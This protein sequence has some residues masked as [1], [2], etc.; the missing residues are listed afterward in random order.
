MGFCFWTPY[1]IGTCDWINF[2]FYRGFSFF[3]HFNDE[4]MFIGV[5]MEWDGSSWFYSG[6]SWVNDGI[7]IGMSIFLNTVNS[8]CTNISKLMLSEHILSE[9]VRFDMGKCV[10]PIHHSAVWAEVP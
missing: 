10:C 7:E 5:F 9:N 6:C 8:I 4:G 1:M 3:E 2:S